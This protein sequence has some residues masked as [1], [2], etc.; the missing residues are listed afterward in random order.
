M[1]T[2]IQLLGFLMCL[3]GWLLSLMSLLNDSW[4]SSTFADQ[5]IT[6][7]W[8]D[9]NLWQSCAEG[10]TGVRNCKQFESMLSLSG[11]IQACRALM[12]IALVLGLLSVV[13]ATMGLKCTKLGS[14]SEESKGKISLT[15]G[16]MFMLSG[17]CVMV[18]VSWYAARVVQEFNDPFYGGTKYELGVGLYLGWAA[19]ALAILGGGILCTSFK[20]SAPAQTRAQS[21]N[22]SAS[23]PQKIYRSAPS[24]NTLSKAYV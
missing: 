17:L 13:L 14:T 3:G 12:I 7:V 16:V 21:Y 19:G 5:L 24:E 11:Y 9:Q 8:Y 6:S 22:Y 15:A 4:R 20:S 18:A 2:G 1:S 10:S 23:Q